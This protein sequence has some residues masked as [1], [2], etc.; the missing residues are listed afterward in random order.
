MLV[1][2]FKLQLGEGDT[3]VGALN[4][5]LARQWATQVV[6]GQTVVFTAIKPAI[7]LPQRVTQR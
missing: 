4:G 2:A 1:R 7:A 5:L 3:L 6:N